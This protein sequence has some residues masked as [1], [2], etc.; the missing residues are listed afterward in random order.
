MEGWVPP[1]PLEV[2]PDRQQLFWLACAAYMSLWNIADSQVGGPEQENVV[3]ATVVLVET[4]DSP[5]LGGSCELGN[6][7]E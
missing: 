3:C 4:G 5:Q 7:Y 6:S 2:Q 1:S